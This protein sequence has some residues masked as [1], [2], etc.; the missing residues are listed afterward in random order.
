[1]IHYSIVI[2]VCNE[3]ENLP[4]LLEELD[5]TITGVSKNFEIIFIDDCSSDGSFEF[6][7]NEK[8][9]R[10]ELR[11][12]RFAENRG[13][14]AALA[15]GFAIAEGDY[16]ITM[17]ADLQNDPADIPNML[18]YLPRFD[19]VTGW[20]QTRCDSLIKKLDSKIANFIRNR[21][22]GENIHDTGCSLKIMRTDILRKIKMYQ[23]MH[24][25]LPTLMKLHGA[26]VKEVP[27][28][29]RY[30]LHGKSKYGTWKRAVG[31]L[32]DLLAIRWMKDRHIH[33]QIEDE[34]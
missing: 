22:T 33:F 31:G 28:R 5:R 6:I 20:R 15:A 8:K 3:L 18:K 26:S 32:R 7:L 30:R 17:D 2:P 23:G 11:Y 12:R 19:M 10:P 24:R 9:T 25:F 29:H 4:K 16:V 21:L 14:S 13:Q 1:M 27:V 34:N